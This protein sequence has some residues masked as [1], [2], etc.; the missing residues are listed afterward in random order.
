MRVIAAYKPG[1]MMKSRVYDW[2]ICGNIDGYVSRYCLHIAKLIIIG[3]F[4]QKFYNFFE[5]V[6]LILKNS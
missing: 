1:I 2:Q 4:F 5:N 3:A 6:C